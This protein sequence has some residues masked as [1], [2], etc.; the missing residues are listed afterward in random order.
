M[1][2]KEYVSSSTIDNPPN[3]VAH[4]DEDDNTEGEQV[5]LI[6]DK[7]S[8]VKTR[9]ELLAVK[10]VQRSFAADLTLRLKAT[11]GGKT[12]VIPL[13]QGDYPNTEILQFLALALKSRRSLNVIEAVLDC[14]EQVF[15]A[16]IVKSISAEGTENII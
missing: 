4:D 6:E 1:K 13:L 12:F 11:D 3:G 8:V 5:P 2:E 10:G 15:N 9:E 7:N 16:P 14:P